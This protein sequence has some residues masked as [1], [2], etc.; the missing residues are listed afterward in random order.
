MVDNRVLRQNKNRNNEND[1][2][3]VYVVGQMPRDQTSDYLEGSDS[4][5]DKRRRAL[6]FSDVVSDSADLRRVMDPFYSE[7][8]K[9]PPEDSIVTPASSNVQIRS[10]NSNTRTIPYNNVSSRTQNQ[11]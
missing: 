1:L 2:E 11:S 3:N 5:Q 4:D 7:A 9:T 10:G 8:G 6:P